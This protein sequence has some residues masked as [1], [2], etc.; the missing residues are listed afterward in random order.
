[1]EIIYCFLPSNRGPLS[2]APMTTSRTLKNPFRPDKQSAC[3]A[4]SLRLFFHRFHILTSELFGQKIND[5][6]FD[7]KKLASKAHNYIIRI[8]AY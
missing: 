2:R 5:L 7:E 3:S 6:N 8:G 4:I 1:M